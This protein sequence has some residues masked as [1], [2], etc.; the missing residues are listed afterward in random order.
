MSTDAVTASVS[1]PHKVIPI[2]Q[3][4]KHFR[5]EFFALNGSLIRSF[6]YNKD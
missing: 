1:G 2:Q 6:Q 3:G 5:S 4:L